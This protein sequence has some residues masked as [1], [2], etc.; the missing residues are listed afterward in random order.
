MCI[1]I[2]AEHSIDQVWAGCGG[3]GGVGVYWKSQWH[4]IF[5]LNYEKNENA[6]SIKTIQNDI[7]EADLEENHYDIILAGMVLHHL[8]DDQDWE[9]TFKKI[10]EP[11]NS[12]QETMIKR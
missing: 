3:V 8:R 1:C 4:N 12:T 11:P 2:L 9:N 10:Y 6:H 5:F 7:R